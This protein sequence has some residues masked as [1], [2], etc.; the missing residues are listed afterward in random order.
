M[1]RLAV[2]LSKSTCAVAEEPRRL[3]D[4][5]TKQPKTNDNGETLSGLKILVQSA[6]EMS[7]INVT[8][9]TSAVPERLQIN[10]PVTITGLVGSPSVDKANRPVVY[11]DAEKIESVA[12]ST[13]K[14]AA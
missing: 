5:N 1:R 4:Y 13:T 12:K 9:P 6:S 11:F 14:A 8:V 10:E 2:D 3:T 7:I